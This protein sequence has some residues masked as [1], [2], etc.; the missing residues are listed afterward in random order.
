ML[1]V[2]TGT[3]GF[4]ILLYTSIDYMVTS[5]VSGGN[6][7]LRNGKLR[8]HPSLFKPWGFYYIAN[9]IHMDVVTN[10]WDILF[11]KPLNKFH[12]SICI[13]YYGIYTW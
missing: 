8:L 9:T 5:T 7:R 12:I 1:K 2:I 6:D 11:N 3:S 10:E 4:S 13:I